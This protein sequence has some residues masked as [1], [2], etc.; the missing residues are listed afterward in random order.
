MKILDVGCGG[1]KWPGAIGMDSNPRVEPDVVHDMD[2]FPYPFADDAFDQVVCVNS[3]EHTPNVIRVLEELH[4][5]TR[6][7]GE[8]Y[9]SSPHFSSHD[10]FTDPTHVHAFSS[11]TIDYMVPG[12]ALHELRYSPRAFRKKR[13]TITFAGYPPGLRHAL[14]WLV[15]LAPVTYERFFAFVVPAHQVQFTLEVVK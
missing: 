1:H 9:V 12:T 7:G 8:V 3:L 15:S 5:V 13:V 10:F 2:V 4:R 14:Q 11:R 6:A